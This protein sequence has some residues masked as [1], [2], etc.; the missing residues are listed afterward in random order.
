MEEIKAFIE[1]LKEER[2]NLNHRLNFVYQ[3][4]FNR[5]A[6]FIRNRIQNINTILDGLESVVNG[7]KKGID[8]KFMWFD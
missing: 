4:K 6:E 7:N 3:H 1:N 5:E 2:T 8:V